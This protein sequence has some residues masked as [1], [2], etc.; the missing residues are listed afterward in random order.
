LSYEVQK[1]QNKR[2]KK[3]EKAV[4]D[5]EQLIEKLEME[6]AAVEEK[7]TTPEGASDMQL[8]N[9]YTDL[10]KILDAAV[11]DWETASMELEE[12]QN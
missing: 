8:I 12:L 4:K 5:C 1:E 6:I 9:Q 10:K 3:A 7:M 11:E 2:R